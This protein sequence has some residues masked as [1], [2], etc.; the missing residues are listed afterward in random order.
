M[1]NN[2]D[3]GELSQVVNLREHWEDEAEDFTP[4]LAKEE[5]LNFLGDAIGINLETVGIEQKVGNFNVDILA[6]DA[7]MEED[8]NV[9]IENQLEKTDHDHLGKLLTYASGYSAKAVVWITKKFN[10]EH[11][12]A[13][14]WLNE[15]SSEDVDFF[16][17]EIE[18][19]KIGDS[20][21]AP[22]FNL[23][24][25]PNGWF[26][27]LRLSRNLQQLTPKQKQKLEFWEKFNEYMEGNETFTLRSP[28]P[29]YWH[30]FSIGKSGY[31]IH[32]NIVSRT[33]K[34]TCFLCIKNKTNGF[35]RL[36]KD[37]EMIE[38]EFGAK[39]EWQY[40]QGLKSSKILKQ[41]TG[42]FTNKDEWE[43]LFKWC[44]ETAENFYKTFSHRIKNL[45]YEEDEEEESAA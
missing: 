22:K 23:V 13:L 43:D 20:K 16:G 34:I 33:K 3:F 17:L 21:V 36:E 25:K 9:I 2:K 24:S 4:W 12:R 27:K 41:R 19:W 1:K 7:D 38:Q 30:V 35:N 28:R 44:K 5:N 39:L 37:K 11:K 32:F 8:N 45:N 15:K 6:K 10:E 14:D 18:L 40:T 26:K 29:A 42:D 31:S